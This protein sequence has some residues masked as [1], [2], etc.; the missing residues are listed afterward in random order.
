ML[1]TKIIVLALAVT[2]LF[3]GSAVAE[4]TDEVRALYEQFVVAQNARD[5]DRVSALFLSSPQFLWV[6]DGMSIW[7]RDATL[8]RMSLFQQAD[9]WHAEPNLSK[10]VA[11]AIDSH[12]ALLHLPLVLTIGPKDRPEKFGFLVTVLGVETV[13][14][15]RIAGLF[16]TTDKSN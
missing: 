10:S 9:V 8:K 7:G 5:L 12:A 15:W 2:V 16:T 13:E 4:P 1:K 11:I 14:G 3:A 6:S